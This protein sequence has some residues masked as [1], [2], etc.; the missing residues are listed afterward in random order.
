MLE[1]LQRQIWSL[2]AAS[3]EELQRR[4]NPT[5]PSTESDRQ[6]DEFV[7]G[8]ASSN[9]RPRSNNGSV[10]SENEAAAAS[11]ATENLVRTSPGNLLDDRNYDER[12]GEGEHLAQ[13]RSNSLIINSTLSRLIFNQSI[14]HYCICIRIF[15]IAA[16]SWLTA[17]TLF[18]FLKVESGCVF[19]CSVSYE[20]NR[21][22]LWNRS[23]IR[24]VFIVNLV[25]N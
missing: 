19:G 22:S 1:D 12:V 16:I 14:K 10:I 23:E 9:S 15:C 24:L 6:A 7:G 4:N 5:N 3:L 8:Q 18:S 2:R 13:L 17:M 21:T 20:E 25:I 11:A